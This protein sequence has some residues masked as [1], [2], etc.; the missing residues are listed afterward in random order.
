MIMTC[1]IIGRKDSTSI[2]CFQTLD[3]TKN[4]K[5]TMYM[6]ITLAVCLILLGASIMVVVH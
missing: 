6:Q 4:V 1:I 5:K 2:S 3:E